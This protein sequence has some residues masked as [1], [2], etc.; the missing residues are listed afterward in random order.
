M[1]IGYPFFKYAELSMR[2]AAAYWR[3]ELRDAIGVDCRR[4][5]CRAGGVVRIDHSGVLRHAAVRRWAVRART[6]GPPSGRWARS[7]LSSGVSRGGRGE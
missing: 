5:G 7:R 1:R 3:R 2:R 6:D 4:A